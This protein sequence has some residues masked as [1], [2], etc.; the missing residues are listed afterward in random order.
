VRVNRPGP[1]ADRLKMVE[2]YM[3]PSRCTRSVWTLRSVSLLGIE[4]RF[5]G[6]QPT[7]WLGLWDADSGSFGIW[8]DSLYIALAS[9]VWFA[10]RYELNLH[11]IFRRDS[12]SI[13]L[14]SSVWTLP[15][16]LITCISA[17]V[18]GLEWGP[19]YRNAGCFLFLLLVAW[20]NE[21]LY[22]GRTVLSCGLCC[23]VVR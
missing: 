6:V 4:P 8:R 3:H 12:L 22:K 2:T 23:R 19:L 15:N 18:S 14:A 17:L 16:V 20:M 13:A 10:V 5:F 1:E 9:S 11:V 21:L 7:R